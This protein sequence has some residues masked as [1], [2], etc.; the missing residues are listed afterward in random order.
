MFI[1]KSVPIMIVGTLFII[2]VKILNSLII[3]NNANKE[4]KGEK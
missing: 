1:R 2:D 4:W 3:V